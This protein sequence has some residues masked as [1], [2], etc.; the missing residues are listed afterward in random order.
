MLQIT[1]LGRLVQ[2]YCYP[3]SGLKKNNTVNTQ[4]YP[5]PTLDGEIRSSLYA[6]YLFERQKF[7]YQSCIFLGDFHDFHYFKMFTD[8]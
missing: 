6:L 1:V 2:N 5:C 4:Y 8:V 7:F 3:A